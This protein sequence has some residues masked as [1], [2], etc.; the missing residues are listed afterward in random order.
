MRSNTAG[1]LQCQRCTA[2]LLLPGGPRSLRPH[3]QQRSAAQRRR[4]RPLPRL[5]T[6]SL[7]GSSEETEQQQQQAPAPSKP[8]IK[9]TM[10]DLDAL[11]GIEEKAEEVRQWAAGG[12]ALPAACVCSFLQPSPGIALIAHPM[13]CPL[14]CVAV[15][16]PCAM[17][18][19]MLPLRLPLPPPPG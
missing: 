4:G 13:I 16:K 14:C 18:P 8:S 7:A 1:A 12:S 3:Q 6:A 11:L 15:H 10:A 17:H 19:C 5:A 9:Q 2:S